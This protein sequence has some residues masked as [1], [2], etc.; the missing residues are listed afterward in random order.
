FSSSRRRSALSQS[1]M[2]PQQG[3]G[4]PD[5]FDAAFCFGAHV[6]VLFGAR[7]LNCR[8]FLRRTG[9]HFGGKRSYGGGRGKRQE[10]HERAGGPTVKRSLWPSSALRRRSSSVV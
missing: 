5:L 7:F 10:P 2:P 8:S 1:K 6:S 4:L 3:D 9:I